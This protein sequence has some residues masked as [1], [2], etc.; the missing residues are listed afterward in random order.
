MNIGTCPLSH[1]ANLIFVFF[2][3][4]ELTSLSGGGVLGDLRDLHV[5]DLRSNQLDKLPDDICA[6][7]ELKVSNF[8]N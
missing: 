7:K 3:N 1:F 6:L 2:Q 4:N 8:L 5:L